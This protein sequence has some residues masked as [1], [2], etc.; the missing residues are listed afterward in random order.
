[1]FLP[2]IYNTV[3][4]H[5]ERGME[6]LLVQIMSKGKEEATVLNVTRAKAA[7]NRCKRLLCL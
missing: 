3:M 6:G 4:H 1:M 7:P 5:Q 2:Q